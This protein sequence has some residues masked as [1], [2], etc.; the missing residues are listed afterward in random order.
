MNSGM[1]EVAQRKMPWDMPG[2]RM[3]GAGIGSKSSRAYSDACTT[4]AMLDAAD[5][6]SISL[7]DV[8]KNRRK[9]CQGRLDDLNHVIDILEKDSNVETAI[10]VVADVINNPF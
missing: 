9:E 6:E 1:A 7:L 8:L 4:S 2:A 3:L 5:S 10:R